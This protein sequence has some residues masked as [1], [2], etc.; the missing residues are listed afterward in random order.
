MNNKRPLF[1]A[2]FLT[3]IAAGAGFAI[4]AV[5]LQDWEGQFGFTKLEL[6]M[7]TG[8]GLTGFGI[9]ILLGSLIAYRVG[10]KT[11]MVLAFG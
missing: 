10:Y 1:L 2:S 3:L 7:I 11:L 8:G 6:G 4:R 5:I 9:V